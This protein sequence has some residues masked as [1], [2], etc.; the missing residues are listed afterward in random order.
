MEHQFEHRIATARV[1]PEDLHEPAPQ[2]HHRKDEH[3]H[4]QGLTEGRCRGPP[5]PLKPA[6]GWNPV[7]TAEQ[8]PKQQQGHHREGE[9]EKEHLET[10]G[11]GGRSGHAE[12]G[13]LEGPLKQLR[14]QNL[15]DQHE[16][17][18]DQECGVHQAQGRPHQ[19]WGRGQ[20]AAGQ[21]PEL[22]AQQQHPRH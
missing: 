13:G 21:Q 18:G 22:P 5:A 7:G 11:Q 9:V 20:P 3:E 17:A 8:A 10:L 15:T 16:A 14:Q 12:Q 19:G 1:T 4:L 6:A 2:G